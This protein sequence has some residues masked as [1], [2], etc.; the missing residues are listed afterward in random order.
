MCLFPGL[1]RDDVRNLCFGSYQ[2][3]QTMPYIQEH[4]TPSP[5]YEDELEFIV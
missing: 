4:L 2:V 1:S 5:L 3:K